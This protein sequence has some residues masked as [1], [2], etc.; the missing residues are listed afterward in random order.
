ML[1]KTAETEFKPRRA[2]L[3]SAEWHWRAE[4]CG[5]TLPPSKVVNVAGGLVLATNGCGYSHFE[6]IY[7]QTSDQSSPVLDLNWDNTPGGPAAAVEF[8][9]RHH[10]FRR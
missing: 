6:G 3:E 8:S 1:G 5:P 4:G 7:L 2:P 9:Y 10:V